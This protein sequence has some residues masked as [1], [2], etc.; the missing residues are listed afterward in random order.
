LK[1]V[2]IGAGGHGQV[3]ADIVRAAQAAGCPVELLGYLDDRK[4]VHGATLAGAPVL[5]PLELLDRL[6]DALI[7]VAIGDNKVRAAINRKL[8]EAGHRAGT[9]IHPKSIVSVDALVGAGSMVCAGAIVN[10]GTAVG[11]G[12]ILNTGCTIDHHTTIGDFTHIAPGVH[13]GGEVTVDEGA[14]VGIGAV[15]LP[16]VKVGAWAVVGAGAV[17]TR[18]VPPGVT[19]VGNPARPLRRRIRQAH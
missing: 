5:G 12:V 15:V 10:T 16:R 13:M 9:A 19:V 6:A 11:R 1:L 4:A 2:V 7:L 3:V 17:V 14:L 8:T 18:D